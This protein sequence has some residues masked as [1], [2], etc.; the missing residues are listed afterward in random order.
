MRIAVAG[1]ALACLTLGVIVVTR[2]GQSAERAIE[3]RER[4]KLRHFA[5][6][7]AAS[8]ARVAASRTMQE[9]ARSGVTRASSLT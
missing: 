3:R 4:Q 9:Y 7:E 8:R 1:L 6:L 2:E 5:R